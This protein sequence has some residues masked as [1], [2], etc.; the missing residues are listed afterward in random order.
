M[1]RNFDIIV[2]KQVKKNSLHSQQTILVLAVLWKTLYLFV[3]SRNYCI[4][5]FKTIAD[6]DKNMTVVRQSLD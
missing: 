5:S 4:Y 3:V 2:P 6:N 1:L